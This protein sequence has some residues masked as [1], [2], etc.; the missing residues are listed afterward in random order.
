MFYLHTRMKGYNV[1]AKISAKD[2]VTFE[3]D[4]LNT[5]LED[6]IYENLDES[7][8]LDGKIRRKRYRM[9]IAPG[10]ENELFDIKITDLNTGEKYTNF[11]AFFADKV[12]SL[13]FLIVYIK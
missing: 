13:T 7:Y 11:K 8:S 1:R 9:M 12:I 10:F 5:R 6:S 2:K 3:D 4:R